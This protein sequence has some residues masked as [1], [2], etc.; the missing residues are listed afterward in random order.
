MA[1]L[2]QTDPEPVRVALPRPAS[3]WLEPG[4]PEWDRA[5]AI[6]SAS[7]G[8]L[9]EDPDTGEVWQYMGTW[10]TATGTFH[11]FRHRHLGG[12]RR[13]YHIPVEA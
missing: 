4:S 7:F 3:P 12:R 1:D 13:V 2:R 5:W 10:E 9:A 8:G 11:E 6:L